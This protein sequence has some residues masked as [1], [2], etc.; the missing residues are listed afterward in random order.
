QIRLYPI[1]DAVYTVTLSYLQKIAEPASDGDS[2][3][4]TEEAEELIRASAI[5]RLRRYD[6][7]DYQGA[8][9]AE[10]EESMHLRRLTKEAR[11]L[12]VGPLV[13]AM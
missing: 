13:G 8:A 3:A 10:A 5:R 2:N 6:L 9:A 4:W 11:M 7:R 12:S 1:P